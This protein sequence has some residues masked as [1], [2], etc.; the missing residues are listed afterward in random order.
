MNELPDFISEYPALFSAIRK[1]VPPSMK[2]YLVGGAVRDV[3][4]GRKISDFDF[5]V[6][7]LVRPIGKH[8]ANELNGAYYV[9]D[10]EREMVRVIVP[11]ELTGQFGVDIA[12]MSGNDIEDDLRE[13]DFTFN[14]MAIELGKTLR[15]VDPLGGQED[16]KN[17]ILRMCAPDSLRNDPMRALRALRMSLEFGLTMD[18]ELIRA[19]EEVPEHMGESSFERYRD[20]LFKIVRLNKNAEAIRFCERF[21]FLDHLFPNHETADGRINVEWIENVDLLSRMIITRSAEEE[22]GDEFLAYASG[23]LG[24][25]KTA[26]VGFFERTLALYHSRKMHLSFAAVARMLSSDTDR[27]KKWCGRLAFSSTETAFV[28]LSIQGFN[29]LNSLPENTSYSD[30]EIYRYFRQFKEGGISAL[31]LFLAEK[32]RN[33]NKPDAYKTWCDHVVFAESLLA[34]FF[35]RYMEVIAPKPILS[36]DDIQAVLNIPAGPEIGY[37]KNSLIEAQIKGS[38]KT[39]SEAEAF[40][41]QLRKTIEKQ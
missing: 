24:N 18:D 22:T 4:L 6:E 29:Y 10:D 31:M 33:Q 40:L 5:S 21:G 2:I 17:G 41:R 30:V 23:R 20:E 32:L 13:R 38:V 36:G 26:L 19:M 1:I 28:L 39:V 34:A 27:I 8:I 7:G 3:L 25:F 37:A 11:D 12:L 15:L 14:A 16:L 35:S 9:L